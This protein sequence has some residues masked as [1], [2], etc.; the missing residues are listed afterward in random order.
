MFIMG[1]TRRGFT[2]EYK[3][4]AVK[5]VI[6]TGR[7]VATV[8]RELGLNEQ[9]LG[10]WVH[11]FKARASAGEAGQGGLTE[12]ERAELLLLRRENSDLKL[13]LAFPEP[14]G[15]RGHAARSSTS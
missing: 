6:N 3:D 14:F 9:T 10:R 4:E 2:P 13:D 15:S 11:D 12:T 5:L 1:R 7:T 8:A